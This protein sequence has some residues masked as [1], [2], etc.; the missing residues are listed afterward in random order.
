MEKLFEN[1][2]TIIRIL[3]TTPCLHDI[4]E[5]YVNRI[6]NK[7]I[8]IS[9]SIK[10]THNHNSESWN[11]KGKFSSRSIIALKRW[12]GCAAINRLNCIYVC[13]DVQC[14]QSQHS[15]LD[16]IISECPTGYTV[17]LKERPSALPLSHQP[18]STFKEP[19]WQKKKKGKKTSDIIQVTGQFTFK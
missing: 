10:L 1:I 8:E 14:R 5:A 6:I 4:S 19:N 7:L 11:T 16:S 17:Y 18:L 12:A 2:K 9:Q 15:A 3:K 13:R